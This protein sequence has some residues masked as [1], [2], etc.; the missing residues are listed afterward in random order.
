MFAVLHFPGFPLQAVLRHEPGAEAK[1]VVLVDPGQITPRVI[2]MNASARAHGVAMGMTA[3]QALARCRSVAIRHRSPAQETSATE[4]ALQCAYGFSPGLETTGPGWIT[5]DLRGL[6]ELRSGASAGEGANAGIYL[7]WGERLLQAVAA[8]GLRA[9]VGLGPTPNVARHA[10]RSGASLA[11]AAARHGRAEPGVESGSGVGT[12][13]GARAGEQHRVG[14]AWVL[15]CGQAPGEGV[16][17]VTQPAVFVKGLPIAALDPSSDVQVILAK[18]G[19]RTVGELLALG[20]TELAERLG[21]EALGLFAAASVTALRPLNCVRPSERFEECHEF[22][23]EVETA[24]PL[25]FL[26]R[27]FAETLGRRLEAF[28]WVAGLLRL[29]LRLENG[30]VVEKELRIPEPTRRSEVL[31]RVLHTHLE[32]LRTDSPVKAV[33]LT[34]EPTRE[35]QRQLGLFESALRDPNQ[36][37]ETLAR[38]AALVGA[39]RVGSPVRENSH[40]PD[41]FVLVPPDFERGDGGRC[42][43]RETAERLEAMNRPTPMRRLRPGVAARV[44]WAGGAKADSGGGPVELK[45]A[46][47]GGRV[48]VALGPWRSSGSWWE[49]GG[50]E[51]EEWDLALRGGPV[52]R[53]ARKDTGPDA[54]WIEA[55]LD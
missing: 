34:A 16:V 22:E 39:D 48:V 28:G 37:Q 7:G 18:W 14:D 40:R 4:T 5:L 33:G 44:V 20:Q 27:R 1:P 3:P 12:G 2:E 52:L 47:A 15:R 17:W 31:F 10:A 50:W 30:R 51:R 46:L 42:V 29:R 13:L 36:F 23:V 9:W 49:A 11:E 6:A 26:L 21:L 35:Q 32:T 8:M 25:L 24:E 55:L 53:L 45:C 19:I 41:A 43:G 38:L 54:G